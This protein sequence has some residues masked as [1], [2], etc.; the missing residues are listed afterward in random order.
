MKT[1]SK[2]LLA[3]GAIAAWALLRK[4]TG[5]AGIG[6]TKRI[7]RR[8]WKEVEAAQKAGIDLSDPN[9]YDGHEGKLDKLMQSNNVDLQP[10]SKPIVQR[11]FNQLRRAY[12]SIAGTTLRPDQH[13]I[14]NEYGDAI[15]IYNDYHL[16]KLPQQAAEWIREQ[17]ARLYGGEED[18]YWQTIADI[19]SGRVKF[20]W[21]SK[22]VHRG[23]Q[24][25]LFGRS[26]PS[27]RKARISYL[28]SP[29]KGGQYPEA[30]AHY[31][32]ETVFQA[33]GDSQ[34]VTDGVLDALRSCNSV[35]EARK[36]C[37]D[38]Y[39]EAHQEQEPLIYQDV[40]F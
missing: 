21:N 37:V 2:I 10:G 7:P 20:V 26:V 6:A 36:I 3:A 40:P 18:A 14:R 17:H 32:W 23:L 33:T 30:Y 31:L 27:E 11:Y 29:E 13:I 4:A 8:I 19:A 25:L 28:A 15:L 16:D 24:Q 5:A 39:M 38:A 1:N 34:E 9:G 35:G 12:K 22:G